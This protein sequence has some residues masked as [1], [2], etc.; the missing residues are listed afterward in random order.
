MQE[1]KTIP[2]HLNDLKIHLIRVIIITLLCFFLCL[3]FAKN[4]FDFAIYAFKM[5]GIKFI[6]T[7]PDGGFNLLIT[8]AFSVC[9]ICLMPYFLLEGLLFGREAIH[10]KKLIFGIYIVS[11]VFYIASM[12][13]SFKI[14]IPLFVK[15]LISIEFKDV[16]FYISTANYI[17]F[18][19]KIA[20]AISVVFQAPIILILLVKSSIVS[21]KKLQQKRRFIFVF[22]F[23]LGALLTP[24][25]VISQIIVGILLYAFYEMVILFCKFS[26][27]NALK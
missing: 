2:E 15:V 21:V 27:S 13:I 18:A 14:L 3:Y 22:C 24:P 6:F 1:K 19:F 11:V 16:E 20:L 26:P 17:S 9:V 8:I 25:D 12:I 4:I 10:N 5:E 23:L 7:S